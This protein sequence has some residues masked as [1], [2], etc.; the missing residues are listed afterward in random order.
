MSNLKVGILVA[1]TKSGEGGRGFY[2]EVKED[3]ICLKFG[4]TL[5]FGQAD[6]QTDRQTD[7]LC[8]YRGVTL[9]KTVNVTYVCI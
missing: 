8:G 7:T 6:R 9:Q 3:D 2:E 1:Q 4:R 5:F